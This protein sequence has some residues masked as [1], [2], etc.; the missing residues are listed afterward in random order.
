MTGIT[1]NRREFLRS[2]GVLAAAGLSLK[3]A[4]V[5]NAADTPPVY[6][7][8]EDLMRSKWTWDRVVRG[9]RGLNCTGHC[10]FNVYVKDGIVWREEQ[11]GEYGRSG[12]DTP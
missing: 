3:Y 10:A 1:A 11:Q 9:S 4:S 8:W 12:E 2:S 6:G 7:R 5:A